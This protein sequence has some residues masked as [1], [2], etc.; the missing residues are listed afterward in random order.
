MEKHEAKAALA[1]AISGYVVKDFSFYDYA[2]RLVEE[3]FFAAW[4]AELATL[5]ARNSELEATQGELRERVR[6]LEED[7]AHLRNCLDV[8]GCDVYV[9]VYGVRLA[10]HGKEWVPKEELGRMS[11]ERDEA[12][13]KLAEAEAVVARVREF[14]AMWRHRLSVTFPL[15]TDLSECA[16]E[17]E[18][19]LKPDQA[20]K[21]ET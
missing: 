13:A 21:G 8:G 10:A 18:A 2:S 19:A 20:A 16:D 17:L 3:P 11:A 15:D 12:R 14:P 9:S 4:F 7:A 6:S 5:R 1:E